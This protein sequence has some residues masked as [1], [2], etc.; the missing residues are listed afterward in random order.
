[1]FTFP[2]C[3]VANKSRS[4]IKLWQASGP[5]F[6]SKLVNLLK[7]DIVARE[8]HKDKHMNTE[9][10]VYYQDLENLQTSSQLQVFRHKPV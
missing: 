1:M 4:S 6:S 8:R 5:M 10:T 7:V 2:T 3:Q 9:F